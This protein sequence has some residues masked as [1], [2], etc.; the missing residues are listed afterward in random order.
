VSNDGLDTA[1]RN[2]CH[3][4]AV[5][6]RLRRCRETAVCPIR[7]QVFWHGA[8]H[9]DVRLRLGK[10]LEVPAAVYL[11]G[12]E[13]RTRHTV[14]DEC[15]V[16]RRPMMLSAACRKSGETRARAF[17]RWLSQIIGAIANDVV[18]RLLDGAG[19]V[20]VAEYQQARAGRQMDLLVCVD[21]C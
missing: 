3:W 4:S 10:W 11:L 8:R 14:V 15:F 17:D 9:P 16:P 1:V 5:L 12:Y 6:K 21:R 2:A 7:A 20:R 19:V 13:R 18:A